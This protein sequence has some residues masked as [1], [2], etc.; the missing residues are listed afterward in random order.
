MLKPDLSA[1]RIVAGTLT[2]LAREIQELGPPLELWTPGLYPERIRELAAD[3]GHGRLAPL[4][5]QSHHPARGLILYADSPTESSFFKVP[6]AR[7]LGPYLVVEDQLDREERC[8]TLARSAIKFAA[9]CGHQRIIMK[10][11]HD[12]A[13]LRGFLAENFV[14]AEIGSSLCG[15]LPDKESGETLRFER[16]PGFVW[17]RGREELLP[18]APEILSSFGDFFYDGHHC[19]SPFFGPEQ[20][21]RFWRQIMLD[22]LQDEATLAL[23]LW[24]Q[25]KDRIAALATVRL[26][27]GREA[28]LSILAVTQNYRGRGLGRLIMLELLERLRGKAKHLRVE[29]ASYNLPALRLYQSLGFFPLAPLVA[30]HYQKEA[31]EFEV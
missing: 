13:I 7:L 3:V 19:H 15:H 8:R 5:V 27:S 14:L 4:W 26:G 12:P 20:A 29:T 23:A 30:L 21:A 17:L 9:S 10:T 11:F 24:D 31:K 1:A 2:L 16:P 18:L 28:V 22:D 6:C 25:R